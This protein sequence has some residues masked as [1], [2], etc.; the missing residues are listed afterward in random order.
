[1]RA[2]RRSVSD[3]SVWRYFTKSGKQLH[4]LAQVCE[5]AVYD[6]LMMRRARH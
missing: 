4:S 1:V 3:A 5:P 2:R 6:A